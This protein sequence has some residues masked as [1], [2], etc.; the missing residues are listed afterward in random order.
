MILS[1]K[2]HSA[3]SKAVKFK[4][5]DLA[6]TSQ[7][8]ENRTNALDKAISII[9]TD[10]KNVH[11][12]LINAPE[13]GYV[14]KANLCY[15]L[16]LFPYSSRQLQVDGYRCRSGETVKVSTCFGYNSL[17]KFIQ[18]EASPD[19]ILEDYETAKSELAHR[20]G[21]FLSFSENNLI[22][23]HS[24]LLRVEIDRPSVSQS[25]IVLEYLLKSSNQ[26]AAHQRIDQNWTQADKRPIS[27]TLIVP[28]TV[29]TELNKRND[30]IFETI[31]IAE[32]DTVLVCGA[33]NCGKSSLIHHLINRQV[34]KKV[35]Q[36]AL[37]LECDPGQTEFAPCGILSLV[38][39]DGQVLSP[40]G[41]KFLSSNR[42]IL[43]SKGK[44]I[45]KIFGTI[46][47]SDHGAKY[48]GLIQQL[49]EEAK[50]LQ[51]LTP[52]P[53]F[54]NTMGWIED[55]GLELLTKIVTLAEPSHVIR[56][57]SN[58]EHFISNMKC[59]QRLDGLH[60][61]KALLPRDISILLSE[62]QKTIGFQLWYTASCVSETFRASLYKT[63]GLR[64]EINQLAYLAASL[65]ADISYIP[66]YAIN[67]TK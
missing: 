64:R 31:Q 66:F 28:D 20:Y 11:Y 26:S 50:R 62:Q 13:N 35:K 53:L 39:V 58:N 55:L 17:I 37:Y 6:P 18:A 2:R 5:S 44:T 61:K 32:H 41:S 29:Y 3:V 21:Q 67:P 30:T 34:S 60:L 43:S 23:G 24:V 42:L 52:M 27:H 12:I 10:D 49:L 59:I 16:K 65:W 33:T 40:P 9:E 19:I 45:S 15:N 56:I 8:F 1:G 46:T 36:S 48:I 4:V 47:P 14:L 22:L 7:S 51:Q 63:S 54:V 38:T 57:Q 25:T